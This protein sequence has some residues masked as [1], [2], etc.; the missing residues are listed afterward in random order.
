MWSSGNSWAF[1]EVQKLIRALQVDSGATQ[2]VPENFRGYHGRSVGCKRSSS[3]FQ[4]VA[5]AF[6]GYFSGVWEI[7]YQGVLGAFQ[8]TGNALKPFWNLTPL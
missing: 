8:I 4:G 1:H 5:R 7:S 3:W 2:D 6:L